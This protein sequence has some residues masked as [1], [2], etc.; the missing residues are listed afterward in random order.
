MIQRPALIPL[1]SCA[2]VVCPQVYNSLPAPAQ[3]VARDLGEVVDAL[4]AHPE[5]TALLA[6]AVGT[7]ILA[8]ALYDR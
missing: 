3:V 8:A 7:P 6:G 2:L 5:G 4:A 1:P